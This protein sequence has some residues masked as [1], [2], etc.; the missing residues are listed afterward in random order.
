M[1]AMDWLQLA[2]FLAV[3]LALTKPLGLYLT[4]VLDSQGRTFLDPIVKPVERL[5]YRAFGIDPT[6]EQDWR[7]Y[8]VAVIA[9]SLVSLLFTYAILRL[10]HLLPL[11]P[12]GLG[13]V[14]DHLAF[15]AAVSF[16]TNTNWQA[17]GGEGTMS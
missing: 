7:R 5:C 14:P 1:N 16:T 13:A 2:L 9:F 12:Q 6:V 8:S 4:R 10:Q 3:L 11:N 17:Y 15:N